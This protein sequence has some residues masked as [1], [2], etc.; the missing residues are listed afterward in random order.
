[1]KNNLNEAR[2]KLDQLFDLC[3]KE[4]ALISQNKCLVL[5]GDTLQNTIA[6][7]WEYSEEL[8]K[9]LEEIEK[10]LIC[11]SEIKELIAD[12]D[13]EINILELN[14][15]C[16]L[17]IIAN[18]NKVIAERKKELFKKVSACVIAFLLITPFFNAL[19]YHPINKI[20]HAAN[21]ER[22]DVI[23]SILTK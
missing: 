20:K 9:R 10:H 23:A 5:G 18:H 3:K 21:L 22:F 6:N 2:S 16:N 11:R 13:F 14:E 17:E 12:I 4:Q 1:M 8:K 7:I 19:N 15:I